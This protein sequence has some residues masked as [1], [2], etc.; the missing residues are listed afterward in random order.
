MHK[1]VFMDI[2]NIIGLSKI[3]WLIMA[4]KM[5]NGEFEIISNSHGIEDK[6]AYYEKAYDDEMRLKT[7][8]DIH[9][10][11]FIIL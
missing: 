4:V 9:I 10:V 2:A 8:P 3:K 6:I 7:C 1:K 5:P 11:D